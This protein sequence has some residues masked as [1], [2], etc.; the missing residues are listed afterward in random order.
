MAASGQSMKRKLYDLSE[1]NR[2]VR[3]YA[4]CVNQ[5][6]LLLYKETTEQDLRVARLKTLQRHS[7]EDEG[8]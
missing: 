6:I 2:T 3:S 4:D 7:E 1:C 5:A 8:E